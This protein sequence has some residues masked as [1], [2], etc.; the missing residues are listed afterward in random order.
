MKSKGKK[1]KKKRE[2]VESEIPLQKHE[3]AERADFSSE[4]QK[5]RTSNVRKYYIGQ[6]VNE[7]GGG[8][9]SGYIIRITPDGPGED[10][11][12]G[13]LEISQD[14][15]TEIA[16]RNTSNPA[17]SPA[18]PPPLAPA[19]ALVHPR[20]PV[21]LPPLL[22]NMS[23]SGKREE[24]MGTVQSIQSSVQDD[25]A[26]YDPSG[27]TRAYVSV[28]TGNIGKYQ[29]GQRVEGLNG[30]A[31]SGTI[32]QIVSNSAHAFVNVTSGPGTIKIEEDPIPNAQ[33]GGEDTARDMEKYSEAAHAIPAARTAPPDETSQSSTPKK[34]VVQASTGNVQKYR[35]GQHVDGLA[36]GTITGIVTQIIPNQ[37]GA[38]SGPGVLTIEE[39]AIEF[40]PDSPPDKPAPAISPHMHGTKQPPT[41]GGYHPD[42]TAQYAPPDQTAQYAVKFREPDR[43]MLG[44][45]KMNLSRNQSQE[46]TDED[47]DLL[48]AERNVLPPEHWAQWQQLAREEIAADRREAKA[49]RRAK[50]VS[51]PLSYEELLDNESTPCCWCLFGAMKSSSG[52]RSGTTRNIKGGGKGG[53]RSSYDRG[54][55][56]GGGSSQSKRG[57]G[58]GGG[59]GGGGGSDRTS[60]WKRAAPRQPTRET[61]PAGQEVSTSNISKYSLGQYV[62]G[63]AGGTITG[64]ITKITP[65]TPGLSSGPGTLVV[66][67]V[68]CMAD[69]K[70]H[71]PTA[72]GN[73]EGGGESMELLYSK[74][75]ASNAETKQTSKLVKSNVQPTGGLKDALIVV[76]DSDSDEDDDEGDDF[77]NSAYD[78]VLNLAGR[79]EPAR[80]YVPPGGSTT[81]M[82]REPVPPGGST[83]IM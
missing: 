17:P 31:I 74:P 55:M 79:V 78:Q 60:P 16:G 66:S 9:A 50:N 24:G 77:V 36:G 76:S 46:L 5:V 51:A 70:I 75:S 8:K 38:V 14:P 65:N 34:A 25:T 4:R 18:P 71:S 11:G 52:G 73:D 49:H 47:L 81:I 41:A 58:G 10:G 15:P 26:N 83:T 44:L 42:Q 37:T 2:S 53:G 1:K 69:P 63:L 33:S 45:L 72:D 20:L 28:A 3:I 35:V 80:T 23:P 30:G 27:Q 48:R 57:S 68:M 82:E 54:G 22:A 67:E 39:D 64:T 29:I 12:P 21:F 7:M 6:Q 19:P 59:G 61:Q 56:Q 43:R 32:V 62:T 13:E 40:L